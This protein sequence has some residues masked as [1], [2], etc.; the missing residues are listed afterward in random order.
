MLVPAIELGEPLTSAISLGAGALVIHFID[1]F[2]PHFH[3]VAGAEG[4]PSKLPR[5]WLMVIAITIH[6]FPEGLAVG[7]SFG[8][9]NATTGLII[10]TAIGLQNMPERLAVALPLLREKVWRFQVYWLWDLNG[11][12]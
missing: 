8:T 1:R 5:V 11:I 3:L 4:P 2:I 6:N 9:G 7:V 10:A 12:S